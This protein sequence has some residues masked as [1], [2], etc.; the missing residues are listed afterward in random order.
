[1]MLVPEGTNATTQEVRA[2]WAYGEMS[3]DRFGPKY[4]A[5]SISK[6][7]LDCA[8]N[9]AVFEDVDKSG[10]EEWDDLRDLART[11]EYLHDSLKQWQSFECAYWSK[12]D[13]ATV[14]AIPAFNKARGRPFPYMDFY[15]GLP[16]TGVK[17]GILGFAEDS[18][19]RVQAFRSPDMPQSQPAV[20]QLF[21]GMHLLVDGYLRSIIF[22]RQAKPDLRFAVWVPVA[23]W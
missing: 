1:M 6:A 9:H 7:I 12:A 16:D 2:R 15:N 13:F 21:K 23:L 4:R 18:D 11:G 10:W 19:P 22:M 5:H 8:D 3:S 17:Q 20:C 14:L